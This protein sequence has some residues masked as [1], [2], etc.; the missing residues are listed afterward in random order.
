MKIRILNLL[1][2]VFAATV[3]LAEAHAA[4]WNE[5]STNSTKRFAFSAEENALLGGGG[6]TTT[7]NHPPF[8]QEV[9]R[10]T[11]TNGG[12]PCAT[13]AF[14]RSRPEL[15]RAPVARRSFVVDRETRLV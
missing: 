9:G 8:L 12:R 11:D 7:R 2:S 15:V 4:T 10:K 5:E 14:A 13:Y 6:R 3:L 1:I